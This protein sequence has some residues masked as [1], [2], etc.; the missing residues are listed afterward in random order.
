MILIFLDDYGGIYKH[1]QFY[2]D[3]QFDQ[4]TNEEGNCIITY[5]IFNKVIDK[6]NCAMIGQH[7]EIIF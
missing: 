5:I 6:F 7:S 4:P 1:L 2:S 3:L